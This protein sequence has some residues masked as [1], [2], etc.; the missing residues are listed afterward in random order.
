MT[1]ARALAA[2]AAKYV[3]R[4]VIMGAGPYRGTIT[5]IT[6]RGIVVKLDPVTG[7]QIAEYLDN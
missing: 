2:L 5:R 7:D 6:G 1:A 4:R 3:G